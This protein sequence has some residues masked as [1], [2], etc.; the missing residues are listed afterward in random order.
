[1][2]RGLLAS[3]V[4]ALLVAL[5][6]P[7]AVFARMRTADS[8]LLQRKRLA[9][10]AHFSHRRF[11]RKV[12]ADGRGLHSRDGSRRN[13][14]Q[15]CGAPLFSGRK[16]RFYSG[17]L[18]FLCRG[19]PGIRRHV[20]FHQTLLSRVG[21]PRVGQF[22]GCRIIGRYLSTGLLMIPSPACRNSISAC[23]CLRNSIAGGR[24]GPASPGDPPP[25]QWNCGD[26]CVPQLELRNEGGE[27]GGAV[28]VKVRLLA[29][30]GRG[31]A[32]LRCCRNGG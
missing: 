10:W 11:Y 18:L 1:M 31:R 22:C 9:S 12:G 32:R 15:S 13:D 16:I 25:R 26:K 3:L 28:A 24:R 2:R 27:E 29:R 4:A 20:I 23:T 6:K 14:W 8:R 19:I 30:R 5:R 7:R 17:L 21:N